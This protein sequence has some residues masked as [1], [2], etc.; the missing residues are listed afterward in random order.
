MSEQLLKAAVRAEE[1]QVVLNRRVE[2]ILSI[3]GLNVVVGDAELGRH[4]RLLTF[5]DLQTY[6]D[7][8]LLA[9][10]VEHCVRHCDRHLKASNP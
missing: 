6:S 8:G 5:L 10:A 4:T 3:S 7:N 9:D 2:I 1:L